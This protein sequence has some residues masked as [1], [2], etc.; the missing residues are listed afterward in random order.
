MYGREIDGRVLTI[1]PS[2][3]TYEDV[4]VLYDKETGSLWYPDWRGLKAIQGELFGER[5]RKLS[6]DDTSW[7]EWV[8]DHPESAILR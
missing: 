8:S 1:A 6:S 7:G 4:F 3:W 2:G 5:L